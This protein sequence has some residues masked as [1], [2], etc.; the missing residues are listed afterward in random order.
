ME[1]NWNSDDAAV[2]LKSA[3]WSQSFPLTRVI[4]VMIII[5]HPGQRKVDFRSWST[6]CPLCTVHWRRDKTFSDWEAPS[7]GSVGW[8]DRRRK[9]SFLI[10]LILIQITLHLQINIDTSTEDEREQWTLFTTVN[11]DW[12]RKLCCGL[13]FQETKGD[14]CKNVIEK[15]LCTTHGKFF[16]KQSTIIL[17]W[18]YRPCSII[19]QLGVSVSPYS[20]ILARAYIT[21]WTR[22][23]TAVG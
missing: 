22:R 15:L 21:T 11:S 17:H 18:N 5:L 16:G 14:P 13:V 10:Y 8:M 6:I 1:F 4:I 3:V 19:I 12:L 7:S 20:S 2:A 9:E 23:T